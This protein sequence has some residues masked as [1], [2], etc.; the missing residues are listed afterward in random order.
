VHPPIL[1]CAEF[2]GF[3]KYVAECKWGGA[4]KIVFSSVALA[5]PLE[6]T[7]IIFLPLLSAR[8]A[9]RDKKC[10]KQETFYFHVHSTAHE[11][12]LGSFQA[13]RNLKTRSVC[14]CARAKRR[15]PTN[16]TLKWIAMQSGSWSRVH[17]SVARRAFSATWQVACPWSTLSSLINVVEVP[18]FLCSFPKC[19]ENDT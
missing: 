14:E 9:P 18:P 6:R 12:V 13:R 3:S 19:R 15:T 8:R 11:Y 7:D 16:K 10:A 17:F 4:R 5:V 1:I 2:V